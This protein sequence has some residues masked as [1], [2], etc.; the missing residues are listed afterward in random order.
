MTA[1]IPGYK[2]GT[3]TID[4]VH[5]DV[6]FTVR[7]MVVSK[8]RGFFRKFE[9]TL[10]TGENPEQSSV[11]ATIYLDSIDT[12]QEQRDA[13]IRSADFFDVDNHPQMTFRST[14][15]RTDGADWFVDGDLTIKGVTKPVSF[16]LEF[17]GAVKDPFGNDRIGLEGSVVVNRKD[18]GINWN[19][20][21]EAGG[22]LVSDKIAL[23]FDISAIRQE[24]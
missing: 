2:A 17:Q 16:P 22:V 8:V 3:W 15:V 21:L 6:S 11:T 19:A 18:W 10:V 5:S 14:S 9:G 13:H 23:E 12:N 24:G 20:A 4:P 7:H 1:Q